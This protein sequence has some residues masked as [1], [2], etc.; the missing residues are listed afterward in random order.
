MGRADLMRRSYRRQ[1]H[2]EADERVV[3]GEERQDKCTAEERAKRRN[4]G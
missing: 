2:P 4:E 1:L 3:Q